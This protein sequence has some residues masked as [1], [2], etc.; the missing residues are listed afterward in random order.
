MKNILLLLILSYSLSGYAQDTLSHI[1]G[2]CIYENR[3][4][5]EDACPEGIH[6]SYENDSLT[7]FGT[8]GANCCGTH[9]AIIENLVDAVYISTIDTGTLCTC[10]CEYCFSIKVPVSTNDTM[11][12]LNGSVYNISRVINSTRN[13]IDYSVE[14]FPNPARSEITVRLL[15]HPDQYERVELIDA[16]GLVVKVKQICRE[17]QICLNLSKIPK[18]TYFIR[19]MSNKAGSITKKVIIE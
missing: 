14:I 18:G 17:S 1:Y 16:Q 7:I 3:L 19:L 5:G 4:T 6:F 15:D 8:I 12:N 9:L 10:T 13:P 2:G 11:V